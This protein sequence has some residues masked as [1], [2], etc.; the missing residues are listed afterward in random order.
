MFIIALEYCYMPLFK[1]PWQKLFPINQKYTFD[2]MNTQVQLN[3]VI[4]V[5]QKAT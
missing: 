2:A 5:A 3:S 4:A 1:N